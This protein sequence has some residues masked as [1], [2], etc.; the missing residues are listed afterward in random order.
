MNVKRYV[1]KTIPEA[2]LMIRKDLGEDALILYSRSINIA[3][4]WMIWKKEDAVEVVATV[5][6]EGRKLDELA[7]EVEEFKREL[8]ILKKSQEELSLIKKI[9]KS[10]EPEVPF[11]KFH[12]FHGK[13]RDS[14]ILISTTGEFEANARY[15]FKGLNFYPFFNERDET[16]A[17]AFLGPTGAGKTTT[18]AKIAARMSLLMKKR[19]C[20]ITLDTFRIAALDQLKAYADIMDLPF[21]VAHSPKELKEVVKKEKS[22]IDVFLIDTMGFSP[23]QDNK[24][25]EISA[26]L[27][28]G[29]NT[30]IHLV[31]CAN[32]KSQELGH[33]INK[34]KTLNP[35]SI[36]WT[37]L[38]EVISLG[39]I[40]ELSIE[41]NLPISL[42]GTGQSVPDNLEVATDEFL[43]NQLNSKYKDFYTEGSKI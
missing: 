17:L 8:Q 22:S 11:L 3:P 41:N 20:L 6:Q 19:V 4:R 26:F 15:F 33:Y 38:D 27:S 24:F 30:E 12:N 40:I 35:V 42:F 9:E 25:K 34:Y 16:S 13:T 32:Y 10:D 31:L 23:F 37:K 29:I 1:A 21:F 39:H 14:S 7:K 28:T 36:I 18:I 5:N 2:I 43:S